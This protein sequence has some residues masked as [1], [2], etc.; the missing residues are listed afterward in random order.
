MPKKRKNPVP[1]NRRRFP[2]RKFI[3]PAGCY[4]WAHN[5]HYDDM[6]DPED[7][8]TRVI[9]LAFI[10]GNGKT[11]HVVIPADEILEMVDDIVVHVRGE[12]GEC[13][14]AEDEKITAESEPRHES[15]RISAQRRRLQED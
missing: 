15:R 5:H 3:Y 14:L 2:D 1:K 13:D 7:K 4:V 9:T 11:V 8:G 12:C 10:K 6:I